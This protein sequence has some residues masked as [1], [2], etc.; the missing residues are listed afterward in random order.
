MLRT[1]PALGILALAC[2]KLVPAGP[3]P[4]KADAG[5]HR[6]V[7]LQLPSTPPAP[8]GVVC[9]GSAA[10]W[11]H[12]VEPQIR[13]DGD[14]AFYVSTE[15]GL[16]AGTIAAKSVD[17]GLHFA[18]LPSPNIGSGGEE[19]G[20]APGGGDTD[21]AIAPVKNAA[22]FHNVY[23]AS[24]SL[25]NVDVSTSTDGGASW[26]LNATAA[27]VAGDDREWIAADGAS[28]VCISYHDMETFNV[29]VDC[30]DDA[31]A[32]FTQH[33]L[34]G[35]IDAAHAFLLENNQIGNLVIDPASHV[36]YQ[37]IAGIADPTE[38][39]CG[40]VFTCKY[41]AVWMAVSTDGGRTFVDYPV[42]VG[43]S[44]QVGY[45][46]QFPNVAVDRAGNVYVAFSDDR[47]VF[48]SYST[49]HGRT[50]SRPVQI[51]RGPAKTAI[52]PWIV[53]GDAGRLKSI[54]SCAVGLPFAFALEIASRSVQLA[55]HVPSPGSATLFTVKVDPAD[56]VTV[57]TCDP[58][59]DAAPG[60]ASSAPSAATTTMTIAMRAR[61]SAR[62]PASDKSC[63]PRRRRMAM[64][65]LPRGCAA[66]C[67][68]SVL[69]TPSAP[70]DE[71]LSAGA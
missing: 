37:V 70:V 15:N 63:P 17:G 58:A 71:E 65:G 66:A 3:P 31:G 20:F 5:E 11:N 16:F 6:F 13:A 32:T 24:L 23:V 12:A 68:L 34:A 33:A 21:V 22:G 50:W 30:S 59:A 19:T 56:A 61:E 14:G 60:A 51:S 35:A 29:N 55:S 40:L 7:N 38:A 36:V 28:K 62:G 25:A 10:C 39:A 26:K 42:Y 53:A 27:R 64:R 67:A 48:Y 43:P 2:M 45:N 18:S 1:W 47:G 69:E 49:D 44:Q 52:F 54:T 9:P 57:T 46:H 41:R 8:V 4:A